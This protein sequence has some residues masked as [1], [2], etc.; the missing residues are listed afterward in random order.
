MCPCLMVAFK[1]IIE[2]F[3]CESLAYRTGVQF[4]QLAD[5]CFWW[6]SHGINEFLFVVNAQVHEVPNGICRLKWFT[7]WI[8]PTIKLHNRNP[9][10]PCERLAGVPAGNHGS[11]QSQFGQLQQMFCYLAYWRSWIWAWWS[12]NGFHGPFPYS[13]SLDRYSSRR[14]TFSK[15]KIQ[16]QSNNQHW[17]KWHDMWDMI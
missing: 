1:F 10:M 5:K 13:L 3:H 6:R 9:V 2:S 17:V 7:F 15:C 11:C 12:N 16:S 4:R 14:N 8:Q